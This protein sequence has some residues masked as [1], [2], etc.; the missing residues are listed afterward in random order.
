MS[1]VDALDPVE[2]EESPAGAGADDGSAEPWQRLHPRLIWVNFGRLVLSLV[3]TAVSFLIFGNSGGWAEN[4]PAMAVT[5]VGLVISGGDVVRWVRTRYRIT[6][7]LVEIRTG[8]LIRMYRQV[9]RDRVRTVDV[10]SRLRHRLTGLRVVFISSGRSRP[11]VKLDAVTKDMALTLQRELL[12][13][14]GRSGAPVPEEKD[15]ELVSVFRWWWIF[16]N[17]LNIWGFLVG[18]LMLWSIDSML[19]IAGLDLIGA[20]DGFIDGHAADGPQTWAWWGLVVAVLG[21]FV[22]LTGFLKNYWLFALARARNEDGNSTLLTRYGMFSTREVHRDERRL[23]GIH[24]SEPLFWRWMRLTET[25]VL[26]TGL[27]T[28]SLS[29]EPAASILPRT[30]LAEARRVASE[31]LPGPVRPL[32]AP[33]RPHPP[34][35][36]RRRL[37]WATVVPGAVAGILYWLGATDA[38]AAWAWQVP[39]WSLP[40]TWLLA[41]LAYRAL[42]HTRA[43]PYLVVRC[44]VSR[45]Q[46]TVLRGDALIGLTMRQSILQR[47]LGLVTVNLSTPVGERFYSAPDMGT[48][49]FLVFS[50]EA[51]PELLSAFMAGPGPD[52]G[53]LFEKS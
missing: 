46:T 41:V 12:Y 18:G 28:F 50:G 25:T 37:V 2:R 17:A 26:S 29:G 52:A 33:L 6:D 34:A 1:A 8:R 40:A 10:K 30:P 23:R 7:D 48:G 3:P 9:P 27:A 5:G 49:Q 19:A 20:L 16:Y 31:I 24:T 39:L 38:V 14:G 13:G 36:L 42:G 4:W 44:G 15:E 53:E 11:A 45:R 35:A 22:L 47:R 51:A 21:H 43:G 32:E